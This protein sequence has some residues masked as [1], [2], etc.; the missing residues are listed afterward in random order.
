MLC[1]GIIL[2]PRWSLLSTLP[3]NKTHTDNDKSCYHLRS[4][5]DSICEKYGLNLGLDPQREK[6]ADKYYDTITIAPVAPATTTE[7]DPTPTLSLV[8]RGSDTGDDTT[9]TTNTATD[10]QAVAERY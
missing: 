9:T 6:A 1:M 3:Y 2:P 7:A 5:L 8:R 10:H 4:L